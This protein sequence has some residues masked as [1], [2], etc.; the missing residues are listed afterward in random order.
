[1][2]TDCRKCG[3]SG[4]T[5]KV[6]KTKGA[7]L[8]KPV[9]TTTV[10]KM[11]TAEI[12]A[13][14]AVNSAAQTK[15]NAMNAVAEAKARADATKKSSPLVKPTTVV[16]TPVAVQPSSSQILTSGSNLPA[17]IQAPVVVPSPISSRCGNPMVSKYC[18]V[19]QKCIGAK[20][21]CS[22]SIPESV[23]TTQIIAPPPSNAAGSAPTSL[24]TI[25]QPSPGKD[26][27]AGPSDKKAEREAEKAARKSSQPQKKLDRAAERAARKGSK[28]KAGETVVVPAIEPS[29]TPVVITTTPNV[30]PVVDTT[31]VVVPTT[32]EI[33]SKEPPS[34]G[35]GLTEYTG[36]T[37]SGSSSQTVRRSG[38]DSQTMRRSGEDVMPEQAFVDKQ[39]V[40]VYYDDNGDLMYFDENN[41]AQFYEQAASS[42]KIIQPTKEGPAVVEKK[43]YVWDDWI[44]S[45]SNDLNKMLS[46]K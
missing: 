1:M 34:Q 11:S 9:A 39:G 20:E 27:S 21:I 25:V 23:P 8:V 37:S 29:T 41:E 36:P 19:Q 3:L 44:A 22:P 2:N 13:Q 31:T 12:M 6:A 45:I 7:P 33:T 28:G 26:I 17:P 5:E 30:V 46:F 10:V 38:E 35:S 32:P 18:D 4:P 14:K 15:L 40:V 43:T 24:T 42:T 16:V